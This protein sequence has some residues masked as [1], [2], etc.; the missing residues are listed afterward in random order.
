[1]FPTSCTTL[2]LVRSV[3]SLWLINAGFVRWLNCQ[4]HFDM[5]LNYWLL[6]SQNCIEVFKFL[7]HF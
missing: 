7:I 1:M 2:V 6:K 4:L 5:L 3:K